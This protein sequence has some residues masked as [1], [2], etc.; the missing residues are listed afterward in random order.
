M[1]ATLFLLGKDPKKLD[2]SGITFPRSTNYPGIDV[3][4]LAA[5]VLDVAPEE[6]V[7]FDHQDE[8]VLVISQGESATEINRGAA[9]RAKDVADT[10][11]GRTHW[12]KQPIWGNC[13]IIERK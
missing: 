6:K 13:L 10:L 12:D 2:V 1:K 9:E 11:D 3:I 5:E 8:D 7:M 4:Q